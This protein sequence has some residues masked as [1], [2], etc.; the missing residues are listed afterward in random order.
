MLL[1]IEAVFSGNSEGTTL[2]L[3]PNPYEKAS[4]AKEDSQFELMHMW[5]GVMVQIF[6]IE[7]IYASIELH[8]ADV[9]T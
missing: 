7:P 6:K 8:F 2:R 3:P 1:A 9:N 4:V 5:P